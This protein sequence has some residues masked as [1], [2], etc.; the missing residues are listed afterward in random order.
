MSDFSL[1]YHLRIG[2][3]GHRN[4]GGS[5]ALEEAVARLIDHL[6]AV[7]ND[8]GQTPLRRTVFS[9]LCGGPIGLSPAMSCGDRTANLWPRFPL[10]PTSIAAISPSLPIGPSSSTCSVRRRKSLRWKTAKKKP[11]REPAP[12]GR[13]RRRC[14]TGRTW[15]PASGLLTIANS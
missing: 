2:V 1:P 14:A 15:P 13:C 8:G 11:T 10:T 9:S 5:H 3:T 12:A 6:Q 7:F 4:L